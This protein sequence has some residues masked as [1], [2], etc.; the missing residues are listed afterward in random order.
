[1]DRLTGLLTDW[2]T[3]GEKGY[4]VVGEQPETG[5][6]QSSMPS[7]KVGRIAIFTLVALVLGFTLYSFSP[8]RH[9]RRN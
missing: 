2:T 4:R 9:R 8:V 7:K 5:R 3:R 6:Y 1:M